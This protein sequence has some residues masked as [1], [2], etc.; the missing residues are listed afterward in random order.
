ML[1][2]ENGV[3]R[4]GPYFSMC[5]PANNKSILCVSIIEN[6]WTA[7]INFFSYWR[8]MFRSHH[9]RV[10]HERRQGRG[11]GRQEVQ[12]VSI[13]RL[14]AISVCCCEITQSFQPFLLFSLF[15]LCFRHHS[16]GHFWRSLRLVLHV[17][18]S[19]RIHQIFIKLPLN[20]MFH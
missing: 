15:V 14:R 16:R 17:H 20:G 11:G 18:E 3:S 13:R 5:Q 8:N 6:Y 19:E 12:L 4:E 10:V 1:C 7:K 9:R 2:S